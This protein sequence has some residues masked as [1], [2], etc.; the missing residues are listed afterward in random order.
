M[1]F[2]MHLMCRYVCML[3]YVQY[4]HVCMQA[5]EIFT[6]KNQ[7]NLQQKKS[8]HG[9]TSDKVATRARRLTNARPSKTIPDSA[10]PASTFLQ[11]ADHSLLAHL[12][13]ER[14]RK[15]QA[16]SETNKHLF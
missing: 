14:E 6:Y 8:R 7:S 15:C 16:E 2:D 9:T 11:T 12:E 4:A 5:N 1:E 10:S 13:M 3:V